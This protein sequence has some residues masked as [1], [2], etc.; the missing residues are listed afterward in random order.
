[1][2]KTIVRILNSGFV[3]HPNKSFRHSIRPF[4]ERMKRY[5]FK[6]I[7]HYKKGEGTTYSSE[8]E[9]KEDWYFFDEKT[10][11]YRINI[12]YLKI[13]R[14]YH[15]GYDIDYIVET[16]V[17]GDSVDIGMADF[18]S[19][20]GKQ[21]D[22]QTFLVNE[23]GPHLSLPAT[24]GGGKTVTFI[25]VAS[26]LGVRTAAVIPPF[27]SDRWMLELS[28][29]TTMNDRD[30][31]YINGGKLLK[32]YMTTI[33]L[34][35]NMFKFVLFSIN[36]LRNYIRDYHE[37]PELWV[38][39]PEEF[40]K[41][42]NFGLKGVDE[43]HKELHFH[44]TSTLFFNTA[45]YINLSGTLKKENEFL[46]EMAERHMPLEGRCPVEEPKAVTDCSVY[47]MYYSH[48]IP[49][50]KSPMGYSHIILENNIR[51]HPSMCRAYM[52]Y[53]AKI[54][55]TE[56][57][58]VRTQKSDKCLMFVATTKLADMLTDFLRTDPAVSMG[59]EGLRVGRLR[60]GEPDEKCQ[61]LD[62]IITTVGRAG[63]GFDVP[64]ILTV[65]N[66]IA[67]SDGPLQ[68]QVLGRGRERDDVNCRYVR[69]YSPHI[70][71]H[72]DYHLKS[73]KVLQNLSN[74]IT[75]RELPGSIPYP[76]SYDQTHAKKI[77]A[78][79]RLAK[80]TKVSKVGKKKRKKK[81]K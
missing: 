19:P 11:E 38:Y 24:M 78:E 12:T 59:F 48:F 4:L 46:N 34:G 81:R 61:E 58:N 51:Y 28:K 69:V 21:E 79:E 33:E 73:L 9:H 10:H 66:T 30:F 36:T 57:C 43:A 53:M 22:W 23:K 64:G 65:V 45:K 15:R 27:L 72:V 7:P 25:A 37:N 63:T 56:F 35:R 75:Y 40:F 71:K 14:E 1:M 76:T 62:L 41:A 47:K 52:I 42:C 49:N 50:H 20:R 54:L 44:F 68:R 67:I 74:S 31:I 39:S 16:P 29:F 8:R 5:E 77:Q 13:F 2:E 70:R 32:S 26:I 55:Y 18:Y 17:I 60:A 80:K 3:V 6:R